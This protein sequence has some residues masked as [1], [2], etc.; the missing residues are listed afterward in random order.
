MDRIE[1]DHAFRHLRRVTL[2][3]SAIGI[4][5]PD[6][7]RRG[8]R[9]S[10]GARI[11]ALG[12]ALSALDDRLRQACCHR[13]LFSS[14]IFRRSSRISGIGCLLTVIDPSALLSTRMLNAA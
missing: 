6:L 7:E 3:L 12:R 13:Y 2:E 5:A 11:T 1:D 10:S 9:L 14:T 8:L 4:A